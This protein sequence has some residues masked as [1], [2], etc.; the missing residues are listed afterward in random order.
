MKEALSQQL[1][2]IT[3]TFRKGSCTGRHQQLE[4]A[5]KH[6]PGI[7]LVKGDPAKN[8]LQLTFTEPT[9]ETLDQVLDAIQVYGC[10]IASGRVE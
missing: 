10:Q 9:K 8:E 7:R 4:E 6:L 2:S 5:I 1:Y 3:L